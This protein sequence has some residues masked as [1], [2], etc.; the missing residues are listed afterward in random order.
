MLHICDKEK[1]THETFIMNVLKKP[2]P[3]NFR[4]SETYGICYSQVSATVLYFTVLFVCS[5]SN[6]NVHIKVQSTETGLI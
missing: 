2:L 4:T 1:L 3:R 5:E 6:I